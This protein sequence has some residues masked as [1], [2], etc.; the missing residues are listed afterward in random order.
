MMLLKE[1]CLIWFYYQIVMDWLHVNKVDLVELLLLWVVLFINESIES[2]ILLLFISISQQDHVISFSSFLFVFEISHYHIHLICFIHTS[3]SSFTWFHLFFC[4]I[5]VSSTH[6]LFL[7]RDSLQYEESLISTDIVSIRKLNQ[8]IVLGFGAG[9]TANR[10]FGVVSAI[11]MS[12]M[13]N[14]PIAC[15]L[16][17]TNDQ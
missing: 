3:S 14:I 8:S 16:V 12:M 9:Q 4:F 6:S 1:H 17:S 10:L 5:V 15:K 13:L 11:V 7:F 2:L